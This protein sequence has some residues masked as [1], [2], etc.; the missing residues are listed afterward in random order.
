MMDILGYFITTII[1]MLA[2]MYVHKLTAPRNRSID[3]R[4]GYE[5]GYTEGLYD[6]AFIY[7]R[8]WED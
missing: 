1:G 8:D 7:G 3:Y 5:D 4:D 6:A 2:G